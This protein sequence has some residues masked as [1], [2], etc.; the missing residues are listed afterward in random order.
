M[1]EIGVKNIVYSKETDEGVKIFKQKIKDYIP[2]VISLGRQFIQG[3]FVPVFRDKA[4]ERIID[5]G[6]DSD[7]ESDNS[8]VYSD[9]SSSTTSSHTYR[10]NNYKK[11]KN[12]RRNK[13][14]YH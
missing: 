12:L 13:W 9:N 5:Y 2:K 14:R 6:S 10:S 11:E 1:V 7:A 4:K 3:G 8:S